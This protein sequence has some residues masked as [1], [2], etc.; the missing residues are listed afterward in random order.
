M[1][2]DF[3]EELKEDLR[4]EK[5]RALWA[6]YGRQFLIGV[7]IVLGIAAAWVG[8]RQWRESVHESAADRFLAAQS[9]FAK[10]DHH[11]AVEQWQSLAKDN[12]NTYRTLARLRLATIEA[13]ALQERVK[14]YKDIAVD[15]SLP[16]SIRD[17]SR[18]MSIL[19]QSNVAAKEELS[20]LLEDLKP[21]LVETCSLAP[22]ANEMAALIL[23]QMGDNAA[24]K[25]HLEVILAM[26]DISPA[27]RARA[28]VFLNQLG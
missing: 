23:K 28:K 3:I 7:A 9:A 1:M 13:T 5:A 27:V 19:M 17:Y 15:Q 6:K 24:A 21:L 4:E 11:Q 18:F 26:P 2:D 20:N 12:D 14:L 16:S 22:L 25:A 8:V 10:G